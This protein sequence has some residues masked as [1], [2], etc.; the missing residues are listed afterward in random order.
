MRNLH[1]LNRDLALWFLTFVL[2]RCE[3]RMALEKAVEVRKVREIQVVGRLRCGESLPEEDL[4]PLYDRLT[5][6]VHDAFAA[7]LFDEGRKIVRSNVQGIGI[8][9]DAHAS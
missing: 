3:T 2:S 8:Q 6:V 5:V 9:R 7:D 1:S 4:C